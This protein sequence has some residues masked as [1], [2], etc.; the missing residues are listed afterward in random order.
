MAGGEESVIGLE[1]VV[2]RIELAHLNTM[3]MA[4]SKAAG[5]IAICEVE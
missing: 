5:S 4:S 3:A 2:E 1:T